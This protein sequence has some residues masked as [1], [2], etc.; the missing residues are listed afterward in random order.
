MTLPF[1]RVGELI[2]GGDA[3]AYDKN[4]LKEF[5]K[6]LQEWQLN[7]Y[8]YKSVRSRR[9]SQEPPYPVSILKKIPK[10][11]SRLKRLLPRSFG[12]RTLQIHPQPLVAQP[13]E[14]DGPISWVL[15]EPDSVEALNL[16]HVD[17]VVCGVWV[18]GSQC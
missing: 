3:R 13:D 7:Y 15:S 6:I 16:S 5:G 17:G 2:L 14:I 9:L 4:S 18:K 10:L 1:G 12:S 8:E 11:L